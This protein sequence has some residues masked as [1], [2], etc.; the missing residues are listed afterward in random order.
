MKRVTSMA[1]I[2]I[3]LVVLAAAGGCIVRRSGYGPPGPPPA[4][5]PPGR[6]P[7]SYEEAVD[8]G[9]RYAQSR[10]YAFRLKKA[11]LE[12]HHHVWE[13][14]FAVHRNDARGE[15]RLAYDAYSRA[16]LSAEEKVKSHR[17]HEHD[18]D[19]DDDDDDHHHKEHGH[20]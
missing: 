15:L 13:V 18:E 8:T 2:P 14:R 16:L 7:M 5:P 9:A 12:H 19:D 20:H 6:P 1:L 10:G 3:A 17:H 4:G 11:E